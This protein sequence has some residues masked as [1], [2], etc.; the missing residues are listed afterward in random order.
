[1]ACRGLSPRPD[2]RYE[3][4]L[5]VTAQKARA[6]ELG[7]EHDQPLADL[8]EVGVVEE[9]GVAVTLEKHWFRSSDQEFTLLLDAPP[10]KARIDPLNKL[11][12]RNPDDN[13]IR[14]VEEAPAVATN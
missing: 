13:V 1:M 4:T 3:L 9:D 10:I 12:D 6:D 2:G 14:A 11:V 7:T 8:I 5:A